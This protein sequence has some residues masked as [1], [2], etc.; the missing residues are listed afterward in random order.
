L[1]EATGQKY[2]EEKVHEAVGHSAQAMNHWKRLLKLATQRPSGITA[3]DTFLHMAP[4][5]TSF[6]G[7]QEIADHCKLLADEAEQ[8]VAD[9]GFPVPDEKY[10]LLCDNIAPWHQLRKM[11]TRLAEL[12]ANITCATYT[13]NIGTIEGG[14]DQVEYDGNNPLWHLARIQNSSVCPYGLE[15]RHQAMTRLVEKNQID[16]VVFA[17]NRSCKV[18]SLMQM[19][20]QKRISR[21]LDIPTTMIDVDHADVRKYDEAGVF[22]RLEALLERIQATRS[23]GT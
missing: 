14:D 5:L 11:S 10:R 4:F 23:C 20:L 15:L 16:A 18:Y 9:G 22:L 6:R 13:S 21:D 1:E 7:T 19:D 12:D 17:S 8:R 3:F 2:D